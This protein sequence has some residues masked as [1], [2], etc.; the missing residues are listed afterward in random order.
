MTHL[1]LEIPRAADTI[2]LGISLPA[3]WAPAI[4]RAAELLRERNPGADDATILEKLVLH[5]I[6]D[7]ID[8]AN[9]DKLWADRN[10]DDDTIIAIVEATL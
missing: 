8:G 5:G 2:V 3:R 9:S 10:E 1:F 4:N 6:V 7:V